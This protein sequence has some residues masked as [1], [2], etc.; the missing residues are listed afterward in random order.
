MRRWYS[1][2]PNGTLRAYGVFSS[3]MLVVAS[4]FLL[5]AFTDILTSISIDVNASG[6]HAVVAFVGG[7][8]RLVNLTSPDKKGKAER[9][10]SNR[11]TEARPG[12]GF[13]AV[14]AARGQ[15]VLYGSV[16]GCVLVWDVKSGQLIYGLEHQEGMCLVF[17]SVCTHA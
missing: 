11:D 3:K 2:I 7:F 12:G 1:E 15:G 17:D 9:E 10:F 8:S 14:Y 13:G 4:T 5:M 16:E 6:S